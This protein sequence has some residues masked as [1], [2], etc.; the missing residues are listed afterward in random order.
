M[1]EPKFRKKS[2]KKLKSKHFRRRTSKRR[3]GNTQSRLP[4]PSLKL[5]PGKRLVRGRAAHEAE[6]NPTADIPE[7]LT[8]AMPANPQPIM[9]FRERDRRPR[10][11]SPSPQNGGRYGVGFFRD[12]KKPRDSVANE[13]LSE[14]LLGEHH[15]E[16][17]KTSNSFMD[18]LKK[19]MRFFNKNKEKTAKKTFIL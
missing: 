12:H 14:P 1:R 19:T 16:N 7:N 8:P 2:S 5:P 6:Y 9:P 10:R 11:R 13:E 3:G 17:A 4:S 15:T 18:R